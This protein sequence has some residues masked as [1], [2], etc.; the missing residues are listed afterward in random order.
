[1]YNYSLDNEGEIVVTWSELLENL[2]ALS[3]ITIQDYVKIRILSHGTFGLTSAFHPYIITILASYT[4]LS[5]SRQ[6]QLRICQ[7]VCRERDTWERMSS[8]T[9]NN[10]ALVLL[11][12]SCEHN[13]IN[14]NLNLRSMSILFTVTSQH[15]AQSLACSRSSVSMCWINKY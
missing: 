14:N 2:S 15:L 12:K 3:C 11:F 1:M 7:N 6:C 4:G 9:E 5:Y 8:T 10:L 13:L